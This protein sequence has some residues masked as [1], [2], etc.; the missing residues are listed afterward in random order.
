MAKRSRLIGLILVVILGIAPSAWA[1]GFLGHRAIGRFAESRL[2]PKAK[3][4]VAGILAKGETLADAST[5][6]DEHRRDYPRSAPWHYVDVPLDEPRYHSLFAGDNA[7]RGYIIDKIH[8]FKV[9]VRD[10]T[11]PIEER[12]I[13]LR[14]LVHFIEDL[15]MPMH[16][17]D[18]NDKGGNRTQVRFFDEGTNMHSLW[19]TRMIERINHSEDFWVKELA[20]YETQNKDALATARQGTIEDWATESLLAAR[21]AY[22]VPESGRRLKSGQ[23]LSQTYVDAN[24]ATLRRRLYLAGAR[25]ALV[26]NEIF[27]E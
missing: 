25:L 27:D 22:K 17:G 21:E 20:A 5:W 14:F 18:N 13:A 11:R 8:D 12:R 24:V 10:K 19:D 7:E 4:A 16:V 26:L 1:W 9:V 23:K 3:A 15:H 2:T 6:A